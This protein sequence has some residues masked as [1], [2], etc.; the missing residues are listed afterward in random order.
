MTTCESLVHSCK[1]KWFG[2]APAFRS[3]K[4]DCARY[5]EFFISS[6]LFLIYFIPKDCIYKKGP[7]TVNYFAS[8][9]RISFTPSCDIATLCSD[10]ASNFV[11]VL[12]QI[13]ASSKVPRPNETQEQLAQ[14]SGFSRALFRRFSFDEISMFSCNHSELTPNWAKQNSRDPGL[15]IKI[16]S[17]AKNRSQIIICGHVDYYLI[18]VPITT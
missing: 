18:L 9:R 14:N 15:E 6:Y 1:R 10:V 16:A 8:V 17:C 7:H 11:S 3:K 13:Q 5:F 4:T 12:T 2:S